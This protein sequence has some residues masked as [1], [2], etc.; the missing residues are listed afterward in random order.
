[1]LDLQAVDLSLQDSHLPPLMM[2]VWSS[3]G[4][5]LYSS[6][7]FARVFDSVSG[8]QL[9]RFKHDKPLHCVAL[10]S[11][12]NVLTSMGWDGT[13]QLYDTESYRQLGQ[14]FGEKDSENLYHVKFSGDGRYLAYGGVT[15]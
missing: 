9:H 8:T 5:K 12:Y 4:S 10:L 15:I 7:N 6:D 2:I 14:P 1:M 11:K 13:A 3:D